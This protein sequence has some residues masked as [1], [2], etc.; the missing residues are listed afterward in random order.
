MHI[1]DIGGGNVRET[2]RPFTETMSGSDGVSGMVRS[3]GL[4]ISLPKPSLL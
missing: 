4:W 3:N 1:E 2:G